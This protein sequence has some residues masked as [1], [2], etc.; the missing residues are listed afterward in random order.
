MSEVHF[1][2]FLVLLFTK[3]IYSIS[4]TYNLFEVLY[5]KVHF[6]YS[7]HSSALLFFNPDWFLLLIVV[8]SPFEFNVSIV[9]IEFKSTILPILFYLPHI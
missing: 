9:V 8:C 4:P 6:L 7:A 5:M 2:S 3:Y 1:D